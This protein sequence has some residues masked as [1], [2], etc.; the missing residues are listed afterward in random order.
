LLEFQRQKTAEKLPGIP[1]F[2]G[3]ATEITS[4]RLELLHQGRFGYFRANI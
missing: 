4:Q 3:I 2:P 1:K